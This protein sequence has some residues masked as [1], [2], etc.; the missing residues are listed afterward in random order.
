MKDLTK[1]LRLISIFERLNK[2][3]VI[4]KSEEAERFDVSKRAIQRDIK[5]LRN[6][7]AGAYNYNDDIKI[8]YDR[9]ENGY[10]LERKDS[11]WLTKEEI[12]AMA[13]VLLESRSFNQEEMNFLL[14]KLISK[15]TP[16][17]RKHIEE[18]IGNERFHYQSLEH[19]KCL[20]ELIWDLSKAVREK[21]IIEVDYIKA[22]ASD[23][24]GRRLKP[25]GIIFSEF[26]F[27]LIAYKCDFDLDSPHVYRL[28]RIEAY[29]I[30]EERFKIPYVERFKEGEFRKRI[31]FMY[32]GELMSINFKF[33]GRS[34]EA[35]LDRLPTAEIIEQNDDEYII[36]A[37]VYGKGIKMWLLSQGNK[38]EVLEPLGLRCEMKEIVE[39]MMGR[40]E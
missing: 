16:K 35:V 13:K 32:L 24:E 1:P 40:Y 5:D 30:G 22:T 6:Y 2:G 27:Y 23:V 28:D 37:E 7:F 18:V 4:N 11:N 9:K 34:V 3:E 12:L 17:E 29:E 26:Y 36:E 39:S 31:Q 15:S 14:E 33:W 8:L 20:F 10:R 21:R 25:V 19:G 38:L